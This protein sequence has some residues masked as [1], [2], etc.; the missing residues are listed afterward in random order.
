MFHFVTPYNASSP[1]SAAVD[2]QVVFHS[3]ATEYL[4]VT[5]G[6]A[7]DKPGLYVIRVFLLSAPSDLDRMVDEGELKRI[8]HI[9]R[10][11][12][13]PKAFFGHRLSRIKTVR[14]KKIKKV[15]CHRYEHEDGHVNWSDPDIP[16]FA[17]GQLIYQDGFE[18]VGVHVRF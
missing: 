15:I 12:I 8:L 18:E 13:D 5:A 1:V 14:S 2:T 16:R 7:T 17:D 6:L 11:E 9:Q 3:V 10:M 4:Q